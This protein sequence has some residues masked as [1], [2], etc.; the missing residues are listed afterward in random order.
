[1]STECSDHLIRLE[2]TVHSAF[3]S[4]TSL[5]EQKR[6]YRGR[7]V[8]I[9]SDGDGA[10][11]SAFVGTRKCNFLVPTPGHVIFVYSGAE[12]MYFSHRTFRLAEEVVKKLVFTMTVTLWFILPLITGSNLDR[13]CAILPL[14]WTSEK[15]SSLCWA[16]L[17]WPD[18]SHRETHTR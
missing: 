10:N 11:S 14:S 15:H 12:A 3:E 7:K 13:S 5:E 4:W 2:G 18:S 9:R 17:E 6:R 1:M 8:W 16:I